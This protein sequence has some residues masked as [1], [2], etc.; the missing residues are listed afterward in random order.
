MNKQII[1][2]LL[3]IGKPYGVRGINF[4]GCVEG[5]AKGFQGAMRRKAHAHWY[6][7]G[8]TPKWHGWICSLSANPIKRFITKDGRPSSLFWHEVAHLYRKS[9][10][11]KQCDKW[12]WSKVRECREV[13]I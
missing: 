10:T 11:E 1:N 5:Q 7:K 3:E 4:G 8:L 2:K 9:W 6:K 12:A 13:I